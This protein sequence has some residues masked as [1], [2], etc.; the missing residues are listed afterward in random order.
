LLCSKLPTTIPL[1]SP[2][3][4]VAVTISLDNDHSPYYSVTFRDAP[5][6]AESRLGITMQPGGLLQSGLKITCI[7]S[8]RQDETW[9]TVV[10]KSKSVRNFYE[11]VTIS[12]QETMGGK[13]RFDLIVRAYNDGV[14]FRYVFT[15][16]KVFEKLQILSEDSEFRFPNDIRCWALKRD[17]FVHSY[18]GPFEPVMLS[19]IAVST[20]RVTN[21]SVLTADLAP[22]GGMAVKFTIE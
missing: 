5:V 21:K 15:G 6:I 1:H 12:S 2:D 18:E 9:Q 7:K 3:P 20:Q 11:Q 13:R 19:Q 10:G 17:G 14:A 8:S 22:G 4:K 16:Q